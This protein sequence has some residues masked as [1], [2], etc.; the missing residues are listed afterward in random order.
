MGL[1]MNQRSEL[2]ALLLI[3]MAASLAMLLGFWAALMIFVTGI[4]ELIKTIVDDPSFSGLGL[5]CLGCGLLFVLNFL[6][7]RVRDRFEDR[8]WELINANGDPNA[9]TP[10]SV[11]NRQANGATPDWRSAQAR[12]SR[13]FSQ[14]LRAL[15]EMAWPS[16]RL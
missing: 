5:M 4:Y 2:R 6:F 11:L 12:R 9:E 15:V 3:W 14:R 1:A 16:S 7:G 10:D 8:C 13:R